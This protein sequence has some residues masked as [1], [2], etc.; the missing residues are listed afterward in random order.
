[1]GAAFLDSLALPPDDFDKIT[2]RN[3]EKLFGLG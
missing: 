3:A 1:V 2:H